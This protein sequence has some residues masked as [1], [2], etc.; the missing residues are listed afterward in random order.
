MENTAVICGQE[1]RGKPTTI[2]CRLCWTSLCALCTVCNGKVSARTVFWYNS[3]KQRILWSTKNK[4]TT[5]LNTEGVTSEL[6]SALLRQTTRAELVP[7][8]SGNA[9]ILSRTVTPRS[10]SGK[11]LIA[12]LGKPYPEPFDWQPSPIVGAMTKGSAM[13]TLETKGKDKW[14]KKL[15]SLF[16]PYVLQWQEEMTKTKRKS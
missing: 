16:F 15:G 8:C 7:R 5:P 6:R 1:N 12:M 11:A 9:L 3:I 13:T 14:G 10:A 4:Q 2:A